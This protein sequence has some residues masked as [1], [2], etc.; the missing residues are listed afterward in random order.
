[1]SVYCH[2]V[3]YVS[4]ILANFVEKTLNEAPLLVTHLKEV[5][6]FS[7]ILPFLVNNGDEKFE[8]LANLQII[9]RRRAYQ[10]CHFRV[11]DTITV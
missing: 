9:G 3:L 5:R 7:S 2:R 10:T 1:M 8:C 6:I 11:A 4:H